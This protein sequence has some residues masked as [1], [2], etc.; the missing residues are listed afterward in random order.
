MCQSLLSVLRSI[1][2]EHHF[3]VETRQYLDLTPSVIL[4]WYTDSAFP[5]TQHK[6]KTLW[7]MRCLT[8]FRE[9]YV[10]TCT[11]RLDSNAVLQ[12]RCH[13]D[14]TETCTHKHIKWKF[15]S[16]NHSHICTG[17]EL[18]DLWKMFS[19][20]ITESFRRSH[21]YHKSLKI[22]FLFWEI[23]HLTFWNFTANFLKALHNRDFN[24]EVKICVSHDAILNFWSWV[25]VQQHVAHKIV[26][27]NNMQ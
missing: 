25:N 5:T 26:I 1:I 22:C 10:D 3:V 19:N 12:K 16:F 18:W 17:I 8:S 2:H 13:K 21:W 24:S 14:Q 9:F 27:I 15:V 11:R 6:I 4:W 7:I 20:G 23:W